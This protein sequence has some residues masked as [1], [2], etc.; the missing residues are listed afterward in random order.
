MSHK[1]TAIDVVLLPSRQMAHKAIQ[2]NQELLKLAENKIVLNEQDCLPHISLCMGVIENAELLQVQAILSNIS[3]SFAPFQ[4]TADS[5]RA[6]TIPTGKKVSG[7]RIKNH[8]LLQKLQSTIMSELWSYLTYDVDAQMLYNPP[9]VEEV[10]FTW[11]RSYAKKHEDPSLFHPHITV[12]FGETG[13]FD[14]EF[15]MSFTASTLA[16]CQLG[17]YCTVRK[18][19]GTFELP[20][21]V[22]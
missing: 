4:L 5:M 6:D 7:L 11:I 15:P 17:N 9:E 1:K 2:I 8:R 18:V 14:D 10:T 12:G 13:A 3:R 19:F 21:S 16:L 20:E 22:T